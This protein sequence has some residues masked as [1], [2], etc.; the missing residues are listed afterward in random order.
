MAAWNARPTRVYTTHY[1]LH[2]LHDNFTHFQQVC[3]CVCVCP[4]VALSKMCTP[5][6]PPL[7]GPNEKRRIASCMCLI[8][9]TTRRATSGIMCTVYFYSAKHRS[10][11]CKHKFERV[12]LHCHRV[13]VKPIVTFAYPRAY[14][15]YT[16]WGGT[17]YNSY[18]YRFPQNG[19]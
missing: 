19:S 13:A 16:S 10:L 12:R 11:Y 15:M 1:T 18:V 8:L 14:M 6:P 3:V 9:Q 17:L 4:S 7:P 5:P 2:T